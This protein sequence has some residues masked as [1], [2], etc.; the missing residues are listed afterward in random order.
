MSTSSP[1]TVRVKVLPIRRLKTADSGY[2]TRR[3]VD[4]AQDVIITE[5]D[6]GTLNGIEVSAIKQGQE[7]LLPLK[8]RIFGRTVCD[9]IYLPG[10]STKILAKCR[11][12]SQLC[13]KLKRSMTAG[14]ESVKNPFRAYLRNAPRRL[15]KVLRHQPCQRQA[16]QPWVK[17]S[18]LLLR[19]RSV[20]LE[21]S[22]RCVRSTWVVLLLPASPLKLSLNTMALSF[23][24]DLRTVKNEEGHWI[25]L[26][27]NG[28]LNIVRDEG[29]T[30]DE[31]KKLLSTKS[32]E[33]L[34]T[35]TIELGTQILLADGSKVKTGTKDRRMGTA[36][37]S[38]YL[39]PPRLCQIRRPCGRDLH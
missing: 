5:E 7:E 29:R 9:D 11:R 28:R 20:N 34:Q 37:H 2:L 19:S 31:Y 36:Q 38:D 3:L 1:L 26:N 22:S 39:R 13:S 17:L 8:D 12:Y 21:R 6:C 16:C 23:T 27:K 10:D 14:I 4:V 18:V 25:A 35:F 24:M 15:R 33:P 30:L 32:I